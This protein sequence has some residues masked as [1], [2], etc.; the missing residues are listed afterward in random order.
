MQTQM[1]IGIQAN[2][3]ALNKSIK[4][5]NKSMKIDLLIIYKIQSKG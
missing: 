1:T 2:L 5:I 4:A 3:D